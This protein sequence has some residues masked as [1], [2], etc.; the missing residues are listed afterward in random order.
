VTYFIDTAIF[1][2]A[3]GSDHPL[4]SPCQSVLGR[5]VR[6]ELVGATSAEVIQELVHRYLSIRR[7]DM[8]VSVAREVLGSF[9]PVLP[10]DHAIVARLP[11]LVS[12]YP[13][14]TTRDLVHV[15]TCIE[16]GIAEIV[17]PD[18]GFDR[19]REIRRI[20]PEALAA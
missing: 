7:T 9:A 2:Y 3:A 13:G 8:A 12:R 11:E 1:M 20:D 16:E 6:G 17:T 15:A 14:L 5:V 18:R 19:V 10:V 4:R